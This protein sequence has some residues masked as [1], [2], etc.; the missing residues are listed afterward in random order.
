M[1]YHLRI[2]DNFHFMDEGEAYNH[3]N[4]IT[5]PEAEAAAREII[6][7]FLQDNLKNGIPFEQLSAQWALYGEEPVI[8]RK[9]GKILSEFSARMCLEMLLAEIKR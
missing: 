2:Y 6:L 5:Y 7:E 8:C 3:G 4:Y 1:P 9:N